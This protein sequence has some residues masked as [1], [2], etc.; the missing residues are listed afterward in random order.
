MAAAQTQQYRCP[1]RGVAV[2]P[3]ASSSI[4]ESESSRAE[5]DV[6]AH[7]DAIAVDRSL[8][9]EK[10]PP[11]CSDDLEREGNEKNLVLESETPAARSPR[12][13]CPG[14][15]RRTRR[16]RRHLPSSRHPRTDTGV[17]V[18]RGTRDVS[19]SIDRLARPATPS[20][21]SQLRRCRCRIYVAR[22]GPPRVT[23]DVVVP[24]QCAAAPVPD[25]HRQTGRVS[26][27]LTA[28]LIVFP[29]TH[30]HARSRSHRRSRNII[31]P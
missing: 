3:L 14:P 4:L 12:Q 29:V 20:N 23:H 1:P 11:V 21:A 2:A 25:G 27:R 31:S 28:R 19:S 7:G 26:P 15:G 10:V 6:Q 5:A 8:N 22:L 13:R 30:T 16:R 17:V 9:G 18:R 24:T